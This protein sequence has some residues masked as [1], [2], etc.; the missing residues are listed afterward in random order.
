[1]FGPESGWDVLTALKDE[2]KMVF[3]PFAFTDGET[4]LTCA[5]GNEY[6]LDNV[7]EYYDEKTFFGIEDSLGYLVQITD[8]KVIVNSAIHAEG[9]CTA[10]PSSVDLY[11]NCWVLEESM[12]VFIRS[13]IKG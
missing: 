7:I 6:L 4:A 8:G 10:P 1:M 2:G 13:F 11:P 5:D 9:G 12:E 3:F